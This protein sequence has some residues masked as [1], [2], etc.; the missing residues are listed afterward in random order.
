[1]NCAGFS[2]HTV[3]DSVAATH[4]YNNSQT[5]PGGF[6]SSGVPKRFHLDNRCSEFIPSSRSPQQDSQREMS[7]F[8]HQMSFLTQHQLGLC[9]PWNQTLNLLS[10]RWEKYHLQI[11]LTKGK[12][13]SFREEATSLRRKCENSHSGSHSGPAL[14]P[15][16]NPGLP[17]S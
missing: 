17:T 15:G 9:I 1:M 8:V 10:G 4:V 5:N 16:Q 12:K 7:Q 11:I 13:S 14:E 2:N 3:Q 6:F